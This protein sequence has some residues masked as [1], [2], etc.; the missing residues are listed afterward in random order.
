M[1]TTWETKC[2]K[3]GDNVYYY[4]AKLLLEGPN[5]PLDLSKNKIVYL[6]CSCDN[7]ISYLF[8]KEFKQI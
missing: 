3:C 8:P 1:T 4:P 2:R 6:T 5:P 7:Q